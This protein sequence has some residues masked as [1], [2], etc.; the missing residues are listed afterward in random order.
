MRKMLKKLFCF[1]SNWIRGRLIGQEPHFN[2]YAIVLGKGRIIPWT[3]RRCGKVK[4]FTEDNPPI[5]YVSE[6]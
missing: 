3:C 5:Q 1:H 6:T 2:D 4:Q